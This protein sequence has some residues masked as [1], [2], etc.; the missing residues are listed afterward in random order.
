MQRFEGGVLHD[1]SLSLFYE[2]SFDV[3]AVDDEGTP[4]RKNILPG[5]IP[6]Y[7]RHILSLRRIWMGY[8]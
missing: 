6:P 5:R 1:L 8:S 7:S 3:E 4:A 2:T